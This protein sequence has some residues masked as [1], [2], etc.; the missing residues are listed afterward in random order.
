MSP[1]PQVEAQVNQEGSL[2]ELDS[3]ETEVVPVAGSEAQSMEREDLQI[4]LSDNAEI[5][6]E[7]VQPFDS[8]QLRDLLKEDRQGYQTNAWWQSKPLAASSLIQ[9][10]STSSAIV[11]H[12]AGSN[13]VL[14]VQPMSQALAVTINNQVITKVYTRSRIRK[15][16]EKEIVPD[17]EMVFL[18]PT[19][20]YNT[21]EDGESSRPLVTKRK[22]T[23]ASEGSLRSSKRNKASNDGFK[24]TSP[25][26]TRKRA[27][28]KKIAAPQI[29]QIGKR[30]LFPIPQ[31]E[32]SDLALIDQIINYALVHSH[33]PIDELQKVARETCGIPPLEVTE[34]PLLAD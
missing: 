18:V 10:G 21:Q 13:A 11:I 32:F 29:S 14:P 24:P 16:E 7:W 12:Q 17:H 4:V 27:A 8:H 3:A 26:L 15:R 6:P 28:V 2:D 20:E 1:Q 30:S 25:V 22:P 9:D 23:P 19:P 33:I 5:M 34:E 31:S